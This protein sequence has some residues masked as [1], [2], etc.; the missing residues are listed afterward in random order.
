MI[1]YVWL[2]ATKNPC[3]WIGRG[4]KPI[5]DQLFV[6][7]VPPPLCEACENTVRVGDLAFLIQDHS[8]ATAPDSTAKGITGFAIKPPIRGMRCLDQ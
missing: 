1:P 8:C 2:G 4:N 7:V 5:S 6:L 3:L